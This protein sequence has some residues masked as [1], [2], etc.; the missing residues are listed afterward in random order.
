VDQVYRP[1]DFEDNFSL[2]LGDFFRS[3]EMQIYFELD[4]DIFYC[5]SFSE[6]VKFYSLNPPL[7][8]TYDNTF[9][10]E[11]I[12]CRAQVNASMY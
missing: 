5:N 7:N 11:Q 4:I 8:I 2:T 12:K 3:I 6:R 1:L 9:D 10:F